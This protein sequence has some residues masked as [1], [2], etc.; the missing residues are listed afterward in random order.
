M[1]AQP[2]FLRGGNY[3]IKAEDDGT[4]MYTSDDGATWHPLAADDI[5]ARLKLERRVE[6][7]EAVINA[8]LGKYVITPDGRLFQYGQRVRFK[9]LNRPGVIDSIH[10]DG[11][12][13]TFS[14]DPHDLD[15]DACGAKF[16][17]VVIGW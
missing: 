16:A 8:L 4:V 3:G 7:L 12:S 9:P 11:V 2:E 15:A 17:D 13:I 1:N 10:E 14:S 6:T 5:Q